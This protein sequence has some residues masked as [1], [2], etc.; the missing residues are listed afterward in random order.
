VQEELSRA[1]SKNKM[2]A[3]SV[4]S[5]VRAPANEDVD[6]KLREREEHIAGLNAEV[7]A[8]K[9]SHEPSQYSSQ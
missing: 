4:T 3:T 6:A 8:L 1:K 2:V 7:T 9:V 5:G